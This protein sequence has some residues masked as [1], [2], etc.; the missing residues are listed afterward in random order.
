[1]FLAS[2]QVARCEVS[3]S[4]SEEGRMCEN[5]DGTERGGGEGGGRRKKLMM[6]GQ[7]WN[8]HTLLVAKTIGIFASW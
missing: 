3:M 1:M 4:T 5:R 8:L 6:M 7:V 2:P